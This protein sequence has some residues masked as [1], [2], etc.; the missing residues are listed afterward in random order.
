MCF[1]DKR[2]TF[3]KSPPKDEALQTL[4]E[5]FKGR[6]HCLPSVITIVRMFI[7]NSSTTSTKILFENNPRVIKDEG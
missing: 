7:L 4:H 2:K 3:T 1:Q 6:I 5:Q